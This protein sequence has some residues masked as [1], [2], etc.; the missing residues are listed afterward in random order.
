MDAGV[1]REGR[2]VVGFAD[3]CIESKHCL[4]DGAKVET[5]T[6]QWATVAYQSAGRGLFAQYDR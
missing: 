4:D 5:S 3:G 1:T 6:E 2:V